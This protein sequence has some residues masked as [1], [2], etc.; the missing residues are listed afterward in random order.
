MKDTSWSLHVLSWRQDSWGLLVSGVHTVCFLVEPRCPGRINLYHGLPK[1]QPENCSGSCPPQSRLS[2]YLWIYVCIIHHQSVLSVIHLSI[3]LSIYL[4]LY[5]SIYLCL[6]LSIYLSIIYLSIY[7]SPICLCKTCLLETSFDWSPLKPSALPV[8][9]GSSSRAVQWV[10]VTDL[11]CGSLLLFP[12]LLP[13]CLPFLLKPVAVSLDT[14]VTG[15][16]WTLVGVFSS[17]GSVLSFPGS[18]EPSLRVEHWYCHVHLEKLILKIKG[19]LT[20]HLK[21]IKLCVW[22]FFVFLLC[23]WIDLDET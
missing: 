6:Y 7:L 20:Q 16:S 9:L 15:M 3:Y 21:F 2:I 23:T 10:V 5:L 17:V 8:F 12:C 4:C 13:S 19:K 1:H 11:G 14:H 22:S 18:D